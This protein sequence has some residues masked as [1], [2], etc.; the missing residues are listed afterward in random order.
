MVLPVSW[1]DWDTDGPRHTSISAQGASWLLTVVSKNSSL[2]TTS[3]PHVRA[4]EPSWLKVAM[5]QCLVTVI[6][7]CLAVSALDSPML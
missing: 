2:N 3:F 1:M 6:R 5:V 4:C 7:D